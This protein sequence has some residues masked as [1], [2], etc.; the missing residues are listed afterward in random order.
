MSKYIDK[1]IGKGSLNIGNKTILSNIGEELKNK[2]FANINSV[3]FP[4]LYDLITPEVKLSFVDK[5]NNSV[6][7]ILLNVNNRTI[8]ENTKLELLKYFIKRGAPIN[9]YNKMKMTPLH[10]AIENGHHLIVKYLLALENININ[11]INNDG[12]TALHIACN[13]EYENIVELLLLNKTIDINIQ[14][15]T[16]YTALMY[17]IALNNFN[18]SINL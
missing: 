18:T 2:I 9:S 6:T 8:P 15:S 13:Y 7:H 16:K 17:S 11:L 5:D 12:Q 1:N 4:I 3:S 10:L 14:D